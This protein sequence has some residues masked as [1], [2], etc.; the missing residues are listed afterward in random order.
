M[1][2]QA[3]RK[4]EYGVPTDRC[5]ATVVLGIEKGF[6]RDEGLDLTVRVIFGGPELSAA[7]DSG[8][9]L[10]GEIGSPPA[11]TAISRGSRFVVVGGGLR[12]GALM[13]LGIRSGIRTWDELRGKRL[14]VLSI[15][16]CTDWIGRAMLQEH[17]LVADHDVEIVP[18]K[19][20]YAKILTIVQQGRVDG[21]VS[22]EPHLAI[23]ET[24]GILKVWAAAFEDTLL[25]RF[26]WYVLVANKSFA[27]SEPATVGA[28]L[29]AYGR[30]SRY[31][32]DHLDELVACSS[33]RYDIPQDAAR[34]AVERELSHLHQGISI[35]LTGLERAVEL[36]QRLGAVPTSFRATHMISSALCA[37]DA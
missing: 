2:K 9:L 36:Q 15:G 11:I 21:V 3:L 34:L 17:G 30:S 1:A 33:E 18:L 6:F 29:R 27:E 5:S 37:V 28:L 31:A 8:G 32:L 24:A 13:F 22:G 25:P 20:D 23:G 12:R 7:Y 10:F 35:D 4:I 16:S 14:G 26:Q 19:D